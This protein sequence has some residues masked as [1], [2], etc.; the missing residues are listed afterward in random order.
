MKHLEQSLAH[1]KN[2]ISG[3]IEDYISNISNIIYVYNIDLYIFMISLYP[4]EVS[5]IKSLVVWVCT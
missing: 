3:I 5:S 2:L 4:S 1:G